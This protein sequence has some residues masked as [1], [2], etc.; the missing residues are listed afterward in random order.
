MKA[1]LYAPPSA[2]IRT[3]SVYREQQ[4]NHDL[5]ALDTIKRLSFA[6]IIDIDTETTAMIKCVII[7]KAVYGILKWRWENID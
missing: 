4:G 6:I 2:I 5:N 1:L 7:N 3:Y